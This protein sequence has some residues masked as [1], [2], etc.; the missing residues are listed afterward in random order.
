MKAA[1]KPGASRAPYVGRVDALSE[2]FVPLLLLALIGFELLPVVGRLFARPRPAAPV[3]V[4]RRVTPREPTRSRVQRRM[5]LASFASSEEGQAP[6][7]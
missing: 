2:V 1:C 6:G 4:A 5:R 3:A 7:G